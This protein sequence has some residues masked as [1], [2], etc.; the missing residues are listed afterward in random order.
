MYEEEIFEQTMDVLDRD[1]SL[2]KELQ[3]DR[4][5][6]YTSTSLMVEQG[7]P[8]SESKMGWVFDAYI[9]DNNKLKPGDTLSVEQ[10]D[11]LYLLNQGVK[12]RQLKVETPNR[13]YDVYDALDRF[14]T[15]EICPFTVARL[16]SLLID[17]GL[18]A[19]SIEIR[20]PDS[21]GWKP[22]KTS[23]G[24]I[25]SIAYP[26]NILDNK[27][28]SITY[29]LGVPPVIRRMGGSLALSAV[30]SFL[31]I[32]CL[33]YQIKTIFKQQRVEELR[34]SFIKTMI[35]ELKRPITALKLSISFMKNEEMMRDEGLKT[36]MLRNARNE[37]DNLSS[38]FS[39]LRD[40]T[41]GDLEQIP[42]NLSALKPSELVM[43]CIA[44]QTFPGERNII[45]ETRFD[46]HDTT[47]RADRMHLANILC[48]LL[49]NAVKYSEG[50]ALIQIKGNLVGDKYQIEIADNGFGIP[51]QEQKYVFDKFFRSASV[52]E[53]NI[54]GIGLGL[55][56]VKLL[57]EAHKGDIYLESETGVGSRFVIEIPS[58][59]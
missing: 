14:Y 9:I 40:L 57:V 17:E 28:V 26:F 58:Q 44:K 45:V 8:A 34:K 7:N 1:R 10:L 51:Y 3:G 16:D 37:L 39:K 2:R 25:I 32:F 27:Q 11:S 46:N 6:T 31:L 22:T 41:Y 23:A 49:E 52:T 18:D 20:Q 29:R 55:C 12:K 15:D 33:I 5:Q 13:E 19:E 35:H 21:T 36:D 54:P 53:K 56:Y 24:S 38:Y 4:F 30:L 59:Q 43:E 48:N 50:D 47:I 42:L